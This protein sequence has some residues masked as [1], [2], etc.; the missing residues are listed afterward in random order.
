MISNHLTFSKPFIRFQVIVGNGW[1]E[2]SRS[3]VIKMLLVSIEQLVIVDSGSL[4]NPRVLM[5]RDGAGFVFQRDPTS[6]Q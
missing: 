6:M 1:G 2:L 5:Q 4:K 3:E